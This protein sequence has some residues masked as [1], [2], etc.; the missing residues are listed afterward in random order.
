M[1]IDI[2]ELTQA[3]FHLVGDEVHDEDGNRVLDSDKYDGKT[4]VTSEKPACPFCEGEWGIYCADCGED[5]LACVCD[6]DTED[7]ITFWCVGCDD[8]FEWDPN[9]QLDEELWDDELEATVVDVVTTTDAKGCICDPPKMFACGICN[10]QRDS[11]TAPWRTF[12]DESSL[13]KLQDADKDVAT[14]T[15]EPEP[16]YYCAKC[17]VSRKTPQGPWVS[18]SPAQKGTITNAKTTEAAKKAADAK[19]ATTTTKTTTSYGYAGYGYGGWSKCRHYGVVLEFP[20]GVKVYPSSMN[21][22]RTAEAPAPDFGLYLDWGWKPEWRAEFIAWPDFNLPKN[23]EAAVDAILEAY[24]RAQK[25]WRVEIGCIGGHGRT[26]TA[27]ACM[28]VLAGLTPKEAIRYVRK[29]YCTET[30]ENDKQ[31]WWVEW[32]D[33]YVNL[34]PLPEKPVFNEKPVFKSSYSTTT[35]GKTT[36]VTGSSCSVQEHYK[37]WYNGATECSVKKK[38]CGFWNTDRKRFEKNDIPQT[39][40]D[41]NAELDAAKK[42]PMVC[43][44]GYMVPKPPLGQEHKPSKKKG[45]G[46]QCDYC[47]Y[48][49]RHGAFLDKMEKPDSIFIACKD[50]QVVPVRIDNVKFKPLPPSGE[51]GRDGVRFGEY[52]W[53]DEYGW[54]W[55]KLNEGTETEQDEAVDRLADAI[56]PN[57]EKTDKPNA[58]FPP[59]DDDYLANRPVIARDTQEPEELVHPEFLRRVQVGLRSKLHGT[60]PSTIE[61]REALRSYDTEQWRDIMDRAKKADTS[62]PGRNGLPQEHIAVVGVPKARLPYYCVTCKD[63]STHRSQEHIAVVGVPKAPTSNGTKI[64]C[65]GC[66]QFVTDHRT[67]TCP[68]DKDLR[69]YIASEDAKITAKEKRERKKKLNKRTKGGKKRAKRSGS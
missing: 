47:R 62:G 9:Y 43:T 49:V 56:E 69:E 6:P 8:T 32:F 66:Q 15:C 2:P 64:F 63:W 31:E 52:V 61:I 38:D 26:G 55:N 34:K 50:G 19:K 11:E 1:T 48:T 36:T 37:M 46:C 54:V 33:A 28:G 24:E 59:D 5:Y 18:L 12:I 29:N 21:N 41:L 40:L 35:T 53:R 23:D 60:E 44:D 25:G 13:V 3:G 10:V 14:C 57:D 22:T 42:V 51:G 27:L 68:V 67:A 16:K 7:A 39:C 65:L 17:G 58:F 30:L 45:G 4:V 20:N